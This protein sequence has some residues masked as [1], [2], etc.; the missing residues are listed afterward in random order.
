MERI[1]NLISEK[2]KKEIYSKFEE[3]DSFVGQEEPPKSDQLFGLFEKKQGDNYKTFMDTRAGQFLDNNKDFL[4]SLLGGI[5]G[6]GAA[7]QTPS[8]VPPPVENKSIF[9]SVWFWMILV[10][11]FMII[12]YFVFL[13]KK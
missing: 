8:Y 4:G 2:K 6:G 1:G 13:R 3:S 12:M 9:Q 11:V 7:S 5:L 10:I